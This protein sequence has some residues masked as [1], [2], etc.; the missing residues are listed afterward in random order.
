MQ[1]RYFGDL[2]TPYRIL[3]NGEVAVNEDGIITYVGARREKAPGEVLDY[4]GD[5]ISP[6]FID[7]HLHGGGGHDFMDATVDAFLGAAEMHARHGTT[8]ML[9][10]SLT[11]SDED[12]FAFFDVYRV[13]RR[14]NLRGSRMPG[15]H[16]EGPY[17][18]KSQKGA[19]DERYIVE[20]KPEHY[21]KILARC[22]EIARW[23][24]AAELPGALELGRYLRS[25]GI[26]ASLGHTD[27]M[28]DDAVLA[29]E[30]GYTLLTH[31][32]SGMSGLVRKN[33]YRVPGLIDA[34][35]MLDFDV[36]IIADGH[37]LPYSLLNYIYRAKGA[38]RVAL[39]TDSLRGAGMPDGESILGS[40]TTGQKCY[41]E[42]GVCKM[43]DRK[44][45]AGSV[46]TTDR[47]VR[48]M[49]KHALVPLPDAVRMATAT[50]ARIMGW[51][52]CGV[53]APGLRA[54]LLVF[55]HEINVKR[56]VIGGN[57][58]FEG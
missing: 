23:S 48:N 36:E 49:V 10:T 37:H 3:E 9:P 19:Q 13:A 2:I 28:Y 52:D 11:S 53:L 14:E 54:D 21:E 31:F 5:L 43:P 7:L 27:A 12:L 45:F 56:T 30:N 47:L 20:P 34:G 24:V 50:P 22:P 39:I 57:C 4:S 1:T 18:A 40:L 15:V 44:A 32:Y 51:T 29:L 33:A 8:T 16:L 26:L 46:A 41:I 6:G 42:D 58:V 38:G 25:R 55:D 35:Y 17:F